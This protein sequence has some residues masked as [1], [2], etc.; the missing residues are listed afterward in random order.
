MPYVMMPVPEEFV[1][2]VMQFILRAIARA[3]IQPWDAES[4]TK[5]FGEVDEASRSL[6]AFVARTP[7][8]DGELDAADAARKIQLTVREAL[9]IMNELNTLTRD[10]DRPNLIN[11]RNV[12]ERLP[13]GRVKDKRVLQM[14]PEVAEFVRAAEQAELLGAPHPLGG[15]TE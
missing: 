10:T 9:G 5:V 7:V 12:T 14:D 4:I 11:A 6:L 2:E 8:E 15:A 1:E 3:S 13:N